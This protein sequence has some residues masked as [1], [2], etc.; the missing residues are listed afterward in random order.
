MLGWVLVMQLSLGHFCSCKQS[1][2]RTAVSN[3][4]KTHRFAKLENF[5]GMHALVLSWAPYLGE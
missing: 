3:P 4:D 1:F 5:G 2:T